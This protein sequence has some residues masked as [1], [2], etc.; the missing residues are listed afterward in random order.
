MIFIDGKFEGG[1][2]DVSSKLKSGK[3]QLEDEED[4]INLYMISNEA[5]IL[6]VIYILYYCIVIKIQK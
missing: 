1:F 5:H 3:I 2:N 4:W 6:V